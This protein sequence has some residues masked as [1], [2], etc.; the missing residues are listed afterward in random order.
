MQLVFV[1]NNIT[2]SKML[3][4]VPKSILIS[5]TDAASWIESSC[6]LWQKQWMWIAWAGEVLIHLWTPLIFPANVAAPTYPWLINFFRSIC[7][8]YM[9]DCKTSAIVPASAEWTW[10]AVKNCYSGFPLFDYLPK[11]DSSWV[12]ISWPHL[13]RWKSKDYLGDYT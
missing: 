7:V 3:V 1:K 2:T 9:K 4:M 5:F 6:N 12:R 10:S 11:M 13:L 8:C